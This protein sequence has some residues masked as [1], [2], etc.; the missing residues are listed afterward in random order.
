MSSTMPRNPAVSKSSAANQSSFA[1]S[2]GKNVPLW[3][4]LERGSENGE[5]SCSQVGI[6]HETQVFLDVSVFFGRSS[7]NIKHM[8]ENQVQC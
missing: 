4:D 8:N 6:S 3:I 1:T 7:N 2:F 5:R